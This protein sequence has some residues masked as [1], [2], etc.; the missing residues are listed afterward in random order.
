MTDYQ[1]FLGWEE[2]VIEQVQRLLRPTVLKKLGL[3]IDE[4][5]FV[6]VKAAYAFNKYR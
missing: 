2:G 4:A 1:A 3:Q 5:V 6:P